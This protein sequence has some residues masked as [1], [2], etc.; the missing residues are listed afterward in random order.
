[1]SL[2]NAAIEPRVRQ[3]VAERLGVSPEDLIAE[4]SLADELA[5]DSLDLLEVAIALEAE[6][7][8]AVAERPL[9][10]VRSYG[11]LVGLVASLVEETR[12]PEPL[13]AP[14]V[15]ARVV[16]ADGSSRGGAVQRALLLTPYAT[17]T[18]AEDAM[19]AG[20]GACLEI[21]LRGRVAAGTVARVRALFA[22]LVERGIPV[23]VGPE[24]LARLTGSRPAA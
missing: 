12:R 20:P 8:I 18:V 1:M 10:G 7:G 21:T 4:A 16:P 23:H 9:A 3:L 19:R 17:E 15:L 24:P 11:D 14:A 13:M 5:V 2:A 6:F 22:R